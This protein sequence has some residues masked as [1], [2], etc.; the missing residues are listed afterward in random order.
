ERE[1]ALLRVWLDDAADALDAFTDLV[2]L[3]QRVPVVVRPI[4][5]PGF[6]PPICR[7]DDYLQS[8]QAPESGDFLWKDLDLTAP[9]L[10]PELLVADPN[11]KARDQVFRDTLTEYFGRTRDDLI[12]ERYV[13]RQ[14]RPDEEDLAFLRR[15]G[16]FA[17]PVPRELGGEGRPKLDYYLLTTN[18][19]R[20]ADV[21]ISLAIQASTSIGTTPVLLARDKDIPRA[22][23]ELQSIDGRSNLHRQ[24]ATALDSAAAHVRET[25]HAGQARA[26]LNASLADPRLSAGAAKSLFAEFRSLWAKLRDADSD[27]ARWQAV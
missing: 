17:M 21:S 23:A 20:I 2:T 3:D 19:Q 8:P 16:F 7:Y 12:Y 10:L 22:L 9:R 4:V 5:E 13:E 18:S 14:H 15:H 1:I 25:G 26:E 27:S 24:I 6:G 11:L